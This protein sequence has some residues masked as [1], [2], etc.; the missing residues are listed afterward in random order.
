M[1]NEEALFIDEEKY[2]EYELK[3]KAFDYL[4]DILEHNKKFTGNIYQNSYM[5]PPDMYNYQN[6][7]LDI[8]SLPTYEIR[9]QVT[10]NESLKDIVL[11]E[12]KERNIE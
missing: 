12:V 2:K 8:H 3:S 6:S 9:L 1:A 4:I 5:N 10:G 11:K 7:Y